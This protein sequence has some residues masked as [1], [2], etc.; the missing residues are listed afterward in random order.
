MPGEAAACQVVFACF[1]CGPLSPLKAGSLQPFVLPELAHPLSE[2]LHL[3]HPRIK[4]AAAELVPGKA[5][6]TELVL[7]KAA[8]SKPP[9]DDLPFTLRRTIC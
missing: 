1:V 7:G 9:A 3:L 2:P 6:T 5:A 8:A 4:A